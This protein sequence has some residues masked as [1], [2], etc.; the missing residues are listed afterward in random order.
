MNLDRLTIIIADDDPD[1]RMLLIEVLEKN[2][3]DRKRFVVAS[4]GDELVSLLPHYS[5]TPSLVFLDLNMPIKNGL[6]ALS[7][8]KTDPSLKHIPVLVLTTSRSSEDIQTCYNLGAATFFTK[9]DS[10]TEMLELGLVVR[11]YW[12]NKAK[13][14]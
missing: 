8:I 13:I 11:N 10:Y 14:P 3:V 5:K 4:D 9:P 7:E 6:K 1:D 12:I 2:G